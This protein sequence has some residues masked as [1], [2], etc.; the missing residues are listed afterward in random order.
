[1]APV[2]LFPLG[3]PKPNDRFTGCPLTLPKRN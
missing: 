2:L 1:M 3:L